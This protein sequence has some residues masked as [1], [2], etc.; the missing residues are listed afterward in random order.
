[1]RNPKLAHIL[2]ANSIPKS[3]GI[4]EFD[5][6]KVPPILTSITLGVLKT[7]NSISYEFGLSCNSFDYSMA[8]VYSPLLYKNANWDYQN[9]DW[10]RMV[11]ENYNANIRNHLVT[12]GVESFDFGGNE[13]IIREVDD[14]I[15][16]VLGILVQ[17]LPQFDYLG[18][19]MFDPQTDRFVHLLQLDLF[20][21]SEVNYY[22]ETYVTLA[23][24]DWIKPAVAMF[25]EAKRGLVLTY[26][27]IPQQFLSNVIVDLTTFYEPVCGRNCSDTYTDFELIIHGVE[28]CGNKKGE[29]FIKRK[30]WDLDFEEDFNCSIAIGEKTCTARYGLCHVHYADMTHIHW[31]MVG[32][33]ISVP[34]W[35][36]DDIVRK[37]GWSID[38]FELIVNSLSNASDI[39]S[40]SYAS[41]E[42]KCPVNTYQNRRDQKTCHACPEGSFTLDTGSTCRDACMYSGTQDGTLLFNSSINSCRF[43][44]IFDTVKEKCGN[45]EFDY[46]ELIDPICENIDDIQSLL[47]SEV[48]ALELI[49][50]AFG[51][52]CGD[53]PWVRKVS[54]RFKSSIC[55]KILYSFILLNVFYSVM[56]TFLEK[57]YKLSYC[58]SL[59]Y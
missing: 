55:Y 8:N 38:S 9:K 30:I 22:I 37:V 45:G 43:W 40:Y 34:D 56:F 28:I 31:T 14:V 39:G 44:N 13:R 32:E 57:Q 4:W 29:N 46:I 24:E 7:V 21:Q 12:I 36:D 48:L 18:S 26:P 23:I 1:M 27:E 16:S 20:S 15:Q 58:S 33:N 52:V 19:T 53:Y 3:D 47:K 11:R 59:N 35:S 6:T 5:C 49:S 50:E 10:E 42:T 51:D 17:V 2:V 25:N 41:T 54:Q